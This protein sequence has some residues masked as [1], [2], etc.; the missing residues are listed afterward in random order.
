MSRSLIQFL[1]F[2]RLICPRHHTGSCGSS[3]SQQKY[4][5]KIFVYSGNTEVGASASDL[6][7]PL[8]GSDSICVHDEVELAKWERDGRI[9]QA[10]GTAPSN[11]RQLIKHEIILNFG[12]KMSDWLQSCWRGPQQSDHKG[13]VVLVKGLQVVQRLRDLELGSHIDSTVH[14]VL[15]LRFKTNMAGQW[16]T[17][18]SRERME[19]D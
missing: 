18:S 8:K 11:L 7:M 12:G 15:I 13:F 2:V 9:F 16:R 5:V 19:K 14:F 6:T 4:I 17:D 1:S 10:N 3:K